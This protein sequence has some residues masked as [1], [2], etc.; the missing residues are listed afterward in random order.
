MQ[1]E[2]FIGK[3]VI[4]VHVVTALVEASS[5]TISALG[6]FGCHGQDL[7]NE[8]SFKITVVQPWDSKE[9]M[10]TSV[11]GRHG[12]EALTILMLRGR[13]SQAEEAAHTKASRCPIACFE[14]QM[15]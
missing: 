7:A 1:K 15:F 8:D 2:T 11:G 12:G 5:G 14:R 9:E 10:M 3:Q 13:V 6:H 4:L